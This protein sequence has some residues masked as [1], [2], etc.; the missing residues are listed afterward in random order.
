M[1]K[2]KKCQIKY[3]LRLRKCHLNMVLQEQKNSDSLSHLDH[4]RFSMKWW[5]LKNMIP[6]Q[7]QMQFQDSMLSL[8]TS[9]MLTKPIVNLGHGEPRKS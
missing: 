2:I 4:R 8:L 6:W 7:T 1:K 3:N 5:R 9:C